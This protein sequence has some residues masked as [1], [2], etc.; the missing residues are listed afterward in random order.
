MKPHIHHLGAEHC[1]TGSCH[2]MQLNG[3]NIM[4][5]CGLSQG[6]DSC[7]PM[8]KWPVSP[9]ALDFLF[10][11]HAH[12]DHIGR[13]PELIQ[14]G[15]KGEIICSHPT[16][17]LLCPM[18]A[19]AMKFSHLSKKEMENLEK[20]IDDLSWGFEYNQSFD[21]KKGITYK[22][23]RAGHILGSS[24]IRFEVDRGWSVIFSGDLGST[25]TPILPDAE[26]PEPA[27]LLVLESTYG[28]RLHEKRD[29]RVQNLGIMLTKAMSNK[30]KVFIPAFALGRTQ[31]LVYEIDRLFTDSKYHEI[32]PELSNKNRPPVFI[33]SPL[34]LNI[35]KI[36]S[37][38]SEYWDKEAKDLHSHGD[39]PIDFKGLYAV[40]NYKDHQKLCS[41][42]GPAVILAGSGMCTGGR[43]INH[44]TA[45]IN[46]S[47]NDICFVGYQAKGT[48]G[49]AIQKYC[50]Y[51]G[52]YVY[53]DGE[54]KFIKATV[55]TLSGY[56]AH[57]D[58]NGLVSWVESIAEKPHAIKL[59][60]GETK[61][62]TALASVLKNKG[63]NVLD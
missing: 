2:L 50:K 18:L 42:N 56:S 28:D 23:G 3:L 37:N 12:I 15:F 22:L 41:T 14:N 9:S 20:I 31:E 40:S 17:S 32:F 33:D 1:V 24:F 29:Q 47:K 38:L 62:R 51:P 39:H 61:A 60:H 58:Q 49:R 43:I 34:G 8:K 10:L 52:G 54:K 27:D 25:N 6:N 13:L 53:L 16:K 19:D 30:G 11:T 21:L 45:G 36:Y 63:Y 55:H 44:L 57:A 59:V 35:T 7:T 26:I 5:D 4:V 46:H 48:P